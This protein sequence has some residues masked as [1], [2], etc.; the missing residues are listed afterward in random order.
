VDVGVY[1]RTMID[2]SLAGRTDAGEFRE[3]IAVAA[4]ELPALRTEEDRQRHL[5]QVVR[6]A[7]DSAGD[8]EVDFRLW[9]TLHW[10]GH[11]FVIRRRPDDEK[12]RFVLLA[13]ENPQ[14]KEASLRRV[15]EDKLPKLLEDAERYDAVPLMVVEAAP[16]Q[17]DFAANGPFI[18]DLAAALA[19]ENLPTG[20]RCVTVAVRASDYMP[21][22]VL[23]DERGNVMQPYDMARERWYA[24]Q[25]RESLRAKSD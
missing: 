22:Y 4:L 1:R 2:G 9:R 10:A 5:D 15:I 24:R 16:E 6:E 14:E 3:R 13:G 25:L 18:N 23:W 7:S 12:S 17:I 20:F 11:A 19:K 8:G 21:V